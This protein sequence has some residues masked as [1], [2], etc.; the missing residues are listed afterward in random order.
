MF[1][2]IGGKLTGLV[3]PDP[4]GNFLNGASVMRQQFRALLQAGIDHLSVK[5][6]AVYL[7]KISR[8]LGNAH[9][10]FPGQGGNVRYQRW[11]DLYS[12]AEGADDLPIFPVQ[13]RSF[14]GLAQSGLRQRDR[15]SSSR[16]SSRILSN[17]S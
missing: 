12:L 16:P 11:I 5:R 14:D 1:S 10:I 17:P 6:R 8:K 2:K 7:S 3:I 4:F 15:F 13:L 9:A